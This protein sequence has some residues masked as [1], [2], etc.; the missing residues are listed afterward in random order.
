M[1]EYEVNEGFDKDVRRVLDDPSFVEFNGIRDL[2][3]V[4]LTALVIRTNTEGE[5]QP[6]KGCP[7]VC[8]KIS[9]LYQL[10]TEAHYI[11]VGEYYYWTHVSDVQ[12][13]AAIHRALS[14]ILVEKVDDAIKLKTRKPD[15]QEFTATIA[16][17][18]AWNEPLL[19]VKEVLR[20]AG[21]QFA[22]SLKSKA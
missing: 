7:V 11:V 16:R 5:H 9:P 17:F 14:T 3:V 8:K 13:D 18:G 12:R 22:E 19:D 15:I 21:K 20:S 1:I 6:G 2:E 10:L 4:I